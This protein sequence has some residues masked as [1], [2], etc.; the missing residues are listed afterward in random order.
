LCASKVVGTVWSY[1]SPSRFRGQVQRSRSGD[2]P[3]Q[4]R[5]LPLRTYKC[6]MFDASIHIGTYSQPVGHGRQMKW[7]VSPNEMGTSAKRLGS[8]CFVWHGT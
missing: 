6:G 3:Q 5:L 7:A 8:Q 1:I 4:P 2:L